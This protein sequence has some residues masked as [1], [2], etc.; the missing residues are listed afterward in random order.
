MVMNDDDEMMKDAMVMTMIVMTATTTT[1]TMM[2]MMIANRQRHRSRSHNEKYELSETYDPTSGHEPIH[3]S[4]S[5]LASKDQRCPE[6]GLGIPKPTSG[7][8]ELESL[9]TRSKVSR[10]QIENS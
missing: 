5:K 4:N 10:G 7:H 6:V 3:I 1:T 2:M 9:A 8:Q